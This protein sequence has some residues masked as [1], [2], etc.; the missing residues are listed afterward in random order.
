[1]IGWK[2]RGVGQ[3][4]FFIGKILGISFRQGVPYG[5]SL[6]IGMFVAITNFS[7]TLD[8]FK[9]VDPEIY[10]SLKYIEQNDPQSLCL[11]FVVEHMLNGKLVEYELIEG[12]KSIDLV[13]AN[14]HKY[15]EAYLKKYFYLGREEQLSE[16]KLGFNTVVFPEY[17]QIFTPLQMLRQIRGEQIVD[18]IFLF[19]Q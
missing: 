17:A 11:R 15:L 2:G 13:Q 5:G 19:I 8:F 3:Q 7:P 1:M 4:A 14:K 9:E 16:L 10:K 18:G 12:G 6:D